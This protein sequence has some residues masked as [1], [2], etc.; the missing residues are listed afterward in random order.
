LIVGLDEQRS[1]L[2]ECGFTRRIARS[3]FGYC[4]P[5]KYTWRSFQTNNTRSSH[6]SCKTSCCWRWIFEHLLWT[7]I[8]LQFIC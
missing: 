3:H 1:V 7:I 6:T 4:C 8:N 5:H 2:K